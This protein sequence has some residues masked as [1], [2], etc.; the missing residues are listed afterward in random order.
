[1][2]PMKQFMLILR[3]Y[4]FIV[5]FLGSIQLGWAKTESVFPPTPEERL[6]Q[7]TQAAQGGNKDAQYM[8]GLTYAQGVLVPRDFT[9]A[10]LWYEKAAKQGDSY[11]QY[12]LGLLY[13]NGQGVAQDFREAIKWLYR[14]ADQG[15]PDAQYG[16]GMM[17]QKGKGVNQNYVIAYAF[18][19]TAATTLPGARYLRT[20][21]T[22]LM[23]NEEIT[24]AQTLSQQMSQ[25]GNL[26]KA[27]DIYFQSETESK[28]G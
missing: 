8:L 17:Y 13:A 23:T 9:K 2:I 28:K 24:T 21:I 15:D 19:N 5:I 18:W 7:M 16:L 22:K 26:L 6:A 10:A 12:N 20:E 3:F 27:L 14:A 1:M 11:A 4:F 25:P